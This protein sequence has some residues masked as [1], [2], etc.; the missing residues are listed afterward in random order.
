MIETR[1]SEKSKCNFFEYRKLP[2]SILFNRRK[3]ILR[4]IG[5]SFLRKNKI[6]SNR[7]KS[8]TIVHKS[9]NICKKYDFAMEQLLLLNF[10]I[11]PITLISQGKRFKTMQL[12]Y[13]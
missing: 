4:Y 7:L 8:L 5:T 11:L 12:I 13:F 10:I 9:N 1:F 3:N 2:P 6:C